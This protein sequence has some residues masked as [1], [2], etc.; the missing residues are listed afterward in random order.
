MIYIVFLKKSSYYVEKLNTKIWWRL[1]CFVNIWLQIVCAVIRITYMYIKYKHS[2]P[3]FESISFNINLLKLD[4]IKL[5]TYM[6]EITDIVVSLF[7]LLRYC[8]VTFMLLFHK[9]IRHKYDGIKSSHE[10]WMDPDKRNMTCWILP[11]AVAGRVAGSSMH[12]PPG[13]TSSSRNNNCWHLSFVYFII[14]P[15]I[16]S[17]CFWC[18]HF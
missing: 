15:W 18:L 8:D 11:A 2:A 3:I 6:Y 9:T 12:G 16:R 10:A 17:I 7:T 5:N 4:L 14:E 13:R 1:L